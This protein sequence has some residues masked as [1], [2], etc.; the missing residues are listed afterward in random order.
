VIRTQPPLRPRPSGF[1]PCSLPVS[2]SNRLFAPEITDGFDPSAPKLTNALGERR[3]AALEKKLPGV[4]QAY[5]QL[6]EMPK[7]PLSRKQ[8]RFLDPMRAESMAL[9]FAGAVLGECARPAYE[10]PE[11]AQL[12]DFKRLLRSAAEAVSKK[13]GIPEEEQLRASRLSRR[14]AASLPVITGQKVSIQRKAT[15]VAAAQCEERQRFQEGAEAQ[16]ESLAPP[17]V[18][19]QPPPPPVVV[20]PPQLPAVPAPLQG[21]LGFAPDWLFSATEVGWGAPAELLAPPPALE[22]YPLEAPLSASQLPA[23]A[24]FTHQP[25]PSDFMY[26]AQPAEQASLPVFPTPALPAPI[27]AEPAPLALDP[28]ALPPDLDAALSSIVLPPEIEARLDAMVREFFDDSRLAGPAPAAAPTSPLIATVEESVQQK[29]GPERLRELEQKLPGISLALQHLIEGRYTAQVT[30]DLDYT[31]PD[32]TGGSTREIAEA[33]LGERELQEATAKQKRT[34]RDMKLT[35]RKVA[36]E[37]SADFRLGPQTRKRA[38]T[39]AMQLQQT[40]PRLAG[41]TSAQISGIYRR[42]DVWCVRVTEGSE[43]VYLGEHPTQEA[44]AL[45]L[46]EYRS[47]NATL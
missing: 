4:T 34:M 23:T 15:R 28:F 16:I 12:G 31:D 11:G 35:L 17:P 18:V 33:V 27:V 13:A 20:P 29:I 44:A 7:A 10:R 6:L 41:E 19:L 46:L 40:M 24:P 8:S 5:A 1:P 25:A 42:A 21:T 2:P 38:L 45:A 43:R 39:L 32:R 36:D 14:L 47:R 22:H 9:L 30:F 26:A 3:R 37:Q